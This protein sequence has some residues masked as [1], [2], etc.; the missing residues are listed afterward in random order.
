MDLQRGRL[1]PSKS[2]MSKVKSTNDE[3]A[4]ITAIF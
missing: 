3:M 4:T 2:V 1:N